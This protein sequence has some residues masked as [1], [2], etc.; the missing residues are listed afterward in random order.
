M[1]YASATEIEPFAG[2]RSPEAHHGAPL[3]A[4]AATVQLPLSARLALVGAEK[5]LFATENAIPLCE[6]V[7][8]QFDVEFCPIN[9]QLVVACPVPSGCTIYV[10]LLSA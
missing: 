1:V 2:P 7:A 3:T 10:P 5:V 4:L 6:T 9:D 8:A